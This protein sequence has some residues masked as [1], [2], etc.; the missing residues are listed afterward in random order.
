MKLYL[1]KHAL[2][3]IRPREAFQ[4]FS[5]LF[6][7]NHLMLYLIS[8]PLHLRFHFHRYLVLIMATVLFII[9]EF[10]NLHEKNPIKMRFRSTARMKK[11]K[12]IS[13]DFKFHANPLNPQFDYNLFSHRKCPVFQTK[14]H[15]KY[16]LK[17]HK[18]ILVLMQIEKQRHSQN[19]EHSLI[20]N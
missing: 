7:P 18:L 10:P 16:I 15:E 6:F 9:D 17:C 4:L 20:H 5:Y 2:Y 12:N 19:I 14:Q 1:R 3:F 8:T 11:C 13:S